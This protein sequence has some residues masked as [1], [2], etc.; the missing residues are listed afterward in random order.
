MFCWG[1]SGSILGSVARI[2]FAHPG[3]GS[4]SSTCCCDELK[5]S[6]RKHAVVAQLVEHHLAKVDVAS[7]SLVNR[8]TEAP[9][10]ASGLFRCLWFLLPLG[11]C[12][13][14]EVQF[15]EVRGGGPAI[16][17][18]VV[19]W[20]GWLPDCFGYLAT[21]LSDNLTVWSPDYREAVQEKIF[22]KIWD[23]KRAGEGVKLLSEPPRSCCEG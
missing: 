18:E 14:R 17:L 2:W 20:V 13:L 10:F 23:A 5:S 8:S 16:F 15:L 6:K 12:C 11:F 22:K 3:K 19:A 7:S 4:Y 1:E 21:G 9:R